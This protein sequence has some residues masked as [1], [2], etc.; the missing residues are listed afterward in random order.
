MKIRKII[1]FSDLINKSTEGFVGRK[2]VHNEVNSFLK[3]DGPQYFLIL[4]EP[5][6]GKTA[7]MAELIKQN[8]YPHHFIGKGSQIDIEST[9]DWYDPVRFAES[10][11]YQLVCDY[12]G[13]I[14][15]WEDWGISV[16]IDIKKAE[17]L[18]MGAE[19]EEFK[20]TPRL[21]DKPKLSVEE[22]IERF[23]A[24]A[25][26]IG[27]YIHE[28]IMDVE[29]IVRQLLVAPLN[30]I[31]EQLPD[32]QVVIVLDGLDEATEY[33]DS[34]RNIMNIVSKIKPHGNIRFLLSSRPGK[35]L[36]DVPGF[37]DKCKIFWL[38]EDEKGNRDPR[39]IED[40]RTFVAKLAE[41]KPIKEMLSV[42]K[43]SPLKLAEKVANAS[44]G[45][46]LYLHHYALGLQEKDENMLNLEAL[47]KGLNKIYGYFLSVIRGEQEELYWNQ[48]YKPVLGT[49]AVAKEPLSRRY[50][51]S[52]SKVDEE[53]VGSIIVR[54]K[55]FMDTIGDR[56]QDRR[57]SIYHKTF[58]EYLVS[59]MS[60]DDYIDGTKAHRRIVEYF[61]ERD[62]SWKEAYAMKYL[63]SHMIDG[64]A[65]DDVKTLLTNIDYLEKK[66]AKEEQ[67]SFQ[68][69][70]I[71]LLRNQYIST[72]KLS[73]ILEAVLNTIYEQS[74]DDMNKADWLDTFAYW[75]NEFG[76]EANIEMLSVSKK[77]LKKIA[78]KFDEA[79]GKLSKKLTSDFLKG[80][81]NSWALRFAELRTWVYQRAELYDQCV[82]ACKDAERMCLQEGMEDAYRD[83]GRV[84]FIRMRVHALR[85]LSEREANKSEKAKYE[86]EVQK[87]YDEL[88]EAFSSVGVGS[89]KLTL[90]EW[91]YLEE[92]MDKRLDKILDLSSKMEKI[93]PG[94]FKA[95]VVSNAHDC[96]SAM[97]IIQFFHEN[98]GLVEWIHHR[99]FKVEKFPPEDTLFTVLIGGPK[100]PGISEVAEVFLKTDKEQY[101]QMYSGLYCK[102]YRLKTEKNDSYSYMLGG[103]SKI[104]TLM[105]AFEFTVDTEVIEIIE[106]HSASIK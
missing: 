96:I 32:Q 60:E 67:Y 89:W 37:L 21:V 102:A 59:G 73:E 92:I 22:K 39:T 1:D 51:A 97:H 77:E 63:L 87:A 48:A 29:Q 99:D 106:K 25:K 80:G 85:L 94:N 65:W 7:F 40:A 61:K 79:C 33:S 10:I 70:F 19:V 100:S 105:A 12:G 104:N 78:K 76:V 66:H 43:M 14:M 4:G 36:T 62:S 30:N 83:L 103:I 9:L 11:G 49:L 98:G 82:D 69:D 35:H 31:A 5:G 44:Q 38:S 55:Q 26:A 54:I 72:D 84:E 15:N 68:N 17:G 81:K 57:Y 53:K 20:A 16:K 18:V 50:I 27:V 23:G 24:A 47:P 42:K 2:W 3:D 101:L 64:Q 91:Q 74:E 71:A 52:F 75:I 56:P 13:W 8:S 88:N 28:F 34:S 93:K 6:S 95:K 41:E 58:G 86:I 90:K 46:F 45:N